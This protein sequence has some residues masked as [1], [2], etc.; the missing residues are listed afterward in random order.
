MLTIPSQLVC[1]LCGAVSTEHVERV[2]MVKDGEI[3]VI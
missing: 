3:S 1:Y 2:E